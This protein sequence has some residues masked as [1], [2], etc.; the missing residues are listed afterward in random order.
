MT[1][2]RRS[3]TALR[4]VLSAAVS[5]GGYFRYP[6]G[7]LYQGDNL[8][9]D[10]DPYYWLFNGQ[11]MLGLEQGLVSNPQDSPE[12]SS[13]DL[14][15]GFTYYRGYYDYPF[16]AEGYDPL[17]YRSPRPERDGI[18]TNALLA[19]AY[20]S[21]LQHDREAKTRRGVYGE[22][23]AEWAP[24]AL[25]NELYGAADYARLSGKL[26]GFLPLHSS[27]PEKPGGIGIYAGGFVGADLVAG[28]R[29]P[30]HIRQSFGGISVRPGLGGSVRGL[31]TG[32]FDATFKLAANAELRTI[33]PGLFDGRV[34]PGVVVHSD[35]GYYDDREELSP[36]GEEHTG[37]ALSSG[38]GLSVTAVDVATIVLYTHYLWTETLV[39]GGSWQPVGIGFG[40]HF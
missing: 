16:S 27:A 11:W 5:E 28:D 19:G 7:A 15:T 22:L 8:D 30:A 39:T 37:I 26:Y 13:S 33:L 9:P 31:E 32:R 18:L 10:R 36:S 25:A 20:L 35:F 3:E 17:F 23:A 6:D 4:A 38:L 24:R 34:L 1:P 12:G 2:D 14:I 21:T 40:F 29:I